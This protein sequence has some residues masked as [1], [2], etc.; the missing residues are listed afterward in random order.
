MHSS[1]N[2]RETSGKAVVILSIDIDE[3]VITFAIDT[4]LHSVGKVDV[5]ITGSD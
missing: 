2:T 3:E 5:E 1:E 4:G